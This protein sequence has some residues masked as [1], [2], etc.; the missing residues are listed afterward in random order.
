MTSVF[1][2]NGFANI[3]LGLGKTF[4]ICYRMFQ[5]VNI[6]I[7]FKYLILKPQ[8]NNYLLRRLYSIGS[9]RALVLLLITL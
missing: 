7:A 2:A 1:L 4:T 8:H 5:D 3:P 9:S 6:Y